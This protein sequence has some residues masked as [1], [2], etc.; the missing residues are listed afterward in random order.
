[1]TTDHWMT[2]AAL[3]I[4]AVSLGLNFY[5]LGVHLSSLTRANGSNC[6]QWLLRR[7]AGTQSAGSDFVCLLC[8]L[9]HANAAG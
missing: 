5:V 9:T 2:L 1:M 7:V 4:S 6:S 3:I 8:T